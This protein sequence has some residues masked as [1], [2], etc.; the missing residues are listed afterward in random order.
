MK[1]AKVSLENNQH[2]LSNFFL[3][4]WVSLYDLDILSVRS[5]SHY[6]L[7]IYNRCQRYVEEGTERILT[8]CRI[9]TTELN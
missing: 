7:Q 8:L 5:T 9:K 4:F 6:T 3:S 1:E 2:D